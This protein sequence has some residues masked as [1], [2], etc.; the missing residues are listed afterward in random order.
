MTQRGRQS[1]ASLSVAQNQSVAELKKPEPPE[2]LTE[3]QAEIWRSVVEP[4]RYDWFTKETLGQLENYCRHM[5]DA[6]R[7]S[8]WIDQLWELGKPELKEYDDLLKSRER[9]TRAANALARSMRIT[10]QSTY[11]KTK[12][13]NAKTYKKPWS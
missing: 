7:L 13:K 2:H 5:A 1:A 8:I 12:G 11:D 6:R 4:L 9:E 3:E 10:Q